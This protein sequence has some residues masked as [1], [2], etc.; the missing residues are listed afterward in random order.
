MKKLSYGSLLVSLV[1]LLVV[2]GLYGFVLDIVIITAVGAVLMKKPGLIGKAMAMKPKVLGSVLVVVPTV[3][4]GIAI[5]QGVHEAKVEAEARVVYQSKQ[6]DKKALKAIKFS[7]KKTIAESNEKGDFVYRF[8]AT[9]KNIE[10]NY[11]HS[12][13]KK[14]DAKVKKIGRHSY[15]LAGN[16]NEFKEEDRILFN[17]YLDGERDQTLIKTVTVENRS[18][19]H[20]K[21]VDD[22]IAAASSKAAASSAAAKSSE[23]HSKS[24]SRDME[25]SRKA[26]SEAKEA[27]IASSKAEESS[28]LE[29]LLAESE[30]EERQKADENA[31]NI[32]YAMLSKSNKYADEPYHVTGTVF[33][34]ESDDGAEMLLVDVGGFNFIYV[35]VDGET[36][37][38]EGS[39]VSIY[40]TLLERKTYGTKIGG[41]NTV[42]ALLAAGEDVSVS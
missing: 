28:K 3:L 30:A 23:E 10:V 37:A 14:M 7:A 32:T 39:T 2:F 40:G 38:V 18:A 1:L 34:A 31:A 19:D 11:T 20:K 25:E 35:L 33:Q 41:T 26:S 22:R 15:E 13:D 36:N 24:V 5:A 16:I 9:A 8:T 29:S 27:S 42:P 4:A 17:L 21:F 12:E 6:A